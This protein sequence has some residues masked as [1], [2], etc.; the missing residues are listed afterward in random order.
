MRFKYFLLALIFSIP[1]SSAFPQSAANIFLT[2][3]YLMITTEQQKI[4]LGRYLAANA[5]LA[6]Q[7]MPEWSLDK[8]TQFVNSWVDDH[9]QYIRRDTTAT[10]TAALFAACDKNSR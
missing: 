7:C 9:P 4:Y 10:F 2:S 1:V 3:D 8:S 5:Q 6:N